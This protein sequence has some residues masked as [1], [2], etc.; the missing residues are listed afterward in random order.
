[1]KKRI[2][3][4]TVTLL[5]LFGIAQVTAAAGMGR[6]DDGPPKLNGNNWINPVEALNLTDQQI[7]KMREINQKTYEQTRD[8]RIKRMDCMQELRQ[9]K[10]QKSP[11]K[12]KIEAKLKE[13]SELSEKIR[14]TAQQ[15]KQEFRS[16]L[17]PEQQDKMDQL[18]S[19]KGFF[20]GDC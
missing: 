14:G 12:S 13:I 15:G 6:G 18:K 4:L 17:T 7:V 5:L 20:R 9:L 2:A 10:L 1:M 16:L 11:D 3:L 8:L 19:K